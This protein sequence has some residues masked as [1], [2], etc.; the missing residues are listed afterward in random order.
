MDE[1]ESQI[2]KIQ[3]GSGKSASS[4]IFIM[5]EKADLGTGE[6]YVVAELPLFNPAA[7]E[8]CE[9]ICLAIAS[10]LKRS[11]KRPA[12]GNSFENALAAINEELGKLTALGQAQWT[13]KLSCILGVKE[14][15]NFSIATCGK[16]AAYLLRNREYTD[17]SC[18]PARSQPLKTFENFA[19]GKIRLGD[20]LILST[21]QLFNYLSM[22]RLLEIISRNDFLTATKTI[23]QLLKE[24]AGPQQTFGV[25]LNLQVP[26]GQTPKDSED[27]ENYI[28]EPEPAGGKFLTKAWA[29]LKTAFALDKNAKRIPKVDLP[30]ISFSQ[31]LT[32]LARGTQNLAAKTRGLWQT[33]KTS[34]QSA[35]TLA[36]AQN[37]R[38]LSPQKKF[39]LVSALVLFVAVIANIGIA[40]HLKKITAAQGQTTAR[41]KQT[42]DLLTKAQSALLYKDDQAAAG[43]FAQ[44]KAGLPAAGSIDSAN[45]NLYGQ[46]Q[47]QLAQT[48]GQLEKTVLPQ[49]SDLGAL[50]QANF[51][52]KL[53]GYLG[54]LVNQT[55]VSYNTQNGK[56]EDGALILPR[57]ITSAAYLSGNT[58][59]V[60]STGAMF[61]WDFSSGKLSQPFSQ[62]VPQAADAAGLAEY[63][64]N[65]RVYLA[66]KK[67]GQIVS[68]V[69]SKS[70]FSKPVVAARDNSLN[71]AVDIAID[72]SIYVLTQT[73]ISKFQSG[74]LAD[75]NLNLP[76]P[77]SGT[78]KISTQKDFKYI[79]LLD[80]GNN[81]ILILDKKGGLA[82]SLRSDKF[83]KLKDF[84][85]D[86]K[87]K[88][89]F[90]LNDGS[91]LKVTLP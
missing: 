46:V 52:I 66:D 1:L 91:L 49:V 16:T 10:S 38:R 74:R 44:A 31:R 27:L 81:R 17:I 48:Q 21:P 82:A 61:V 11:Y 85:V 71:Q 84:N 5:A 41:L 60:Y 37:L 51:L 13:D 64:V 6:L 76:T 90:V 70:G 65:S 79:Y 4:F 43:Y 34:A 12:G 47:N 57:A 50:G 88:V 15:E 7:E 45:K 26:L 22:D 86:E 55:I 77:L 23:I 28:V 75:F 30:K 78:G 80:A 20:L 72:G 42:Q 29:Y 89:M 18:S 83:T 87:N 32:G 58:A 8:S 53:P 73:G 2:A 54:V 9:R 24:T 67:L 59:A 39:F 36:T 40:I 62:S 68:F 25:L 35:K 56:I 19:T 69:P 33:A 3:L 63:P 14:S